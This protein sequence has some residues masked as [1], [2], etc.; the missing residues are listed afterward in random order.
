MLNKLLGFI[1][2]YGLLIPILG[3][4]L[5][6]LLDQVDLKL[7][8]D[9][10]YLNINYITF[11]NNKITSAMTDVP[12]TNMREAAS[13][14]AKDNYTY[15]IIFLKDAVGLDSIQLLYVDQ[16][17]DRSSGGEKLFGE[18]GG[19]QID[20]TKLF[21]YKDLWYIQKVRPELY[22]A[23]YN[24]VRRFMLD[25]P[26]QQPPTLLR[27][28][29]DT[30]IKTS[31]GIAA[32]D[33]MDFLSFMRSN[34]LHYYPK[35]KVIEKKGLRKSGPSSD[36]AAVDYRIDA[37]FTGLSFS[38]PAMD[39]SL[40]GASLELGVDERMLNILPYQGGV[41]GGF[42]TLISIADK[43]SDI[44]K[45]FII[46]ATI[47]VRAAV[48][49]SKLPNSL[50]FMG[51]S[52][53][54]LQFGNSGGI[55]LH[56]TRIFGLPFINFYAMAGAVPTLKNS[57]LRQQLN[58]KTMSYYNTASAE[59]T[60]SFYWNTS[61]SNMSRFRLDVGAGYYDVS[62][63]EYSSASASQPFSKKAVYSGI[64]PVLSLHFNFAPD[65]KDNIYYG[66]IRFFDSQLKVNGWLKV[67]E[68]EGGH[69]FRVALTYVTAPFA[70]RQHEWETTGGALVQVR[71]R[72]GL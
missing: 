37:G 39:F 65:G 62:S 28:N 70:R 30:D 43:N 45:A 4:N 21:T 36:S 44:N 19:P 1:V 50:P 55:D 13:F 12:R 40:G 59:G 2:L 24:E 48:D 7:R 71:Y 72:Y 15:N 16:I 51:A 23:L 61:E 67:L 20:T 56:L 46:D 35:A 49:L 69:V 57:P 63:A 3:Q 53:P 34:N 29:P 26:D 27:I 14:V 5:D 54:K 9:K 18:T 6:E 52:K 47:L 10:K 60:M 66:N 31:L 11:P 25:N 41:N 33:N 68:L 58:G 22:S 64:S 32:R 8:K 17:V 38:H 42:R